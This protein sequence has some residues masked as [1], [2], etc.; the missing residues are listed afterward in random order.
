MQL[1]L[2]LSSSNFLTPMLAASS[3]LKAVTLLNSRNLNDNN[4]KNRRR[5]SGKM[6]HHHK[7]TEDAQAYLSQTLPSNLFRYP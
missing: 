2:D 1:P 4:V 6:C 7:N 3:T 5:K